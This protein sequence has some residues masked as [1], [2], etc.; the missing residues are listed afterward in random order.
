MLIV[1]STG[2]LFGLFPG[3]T[4]RTL[5]ENNPLVQQL[6]VQPSELSKHHTDH[7]P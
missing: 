5:R 4:S 2:F 3:V 6:N 7:A 1:P